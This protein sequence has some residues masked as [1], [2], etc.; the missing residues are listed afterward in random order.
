MIVHPY[1]KKP[2]I[3]RIAVV[4]DDGIYVDE[5]GATFTANSEYKFKQGQIVC[6][7]LWDTAI[8]LT[9]NGIG[10][11][12]SWNSKDTRWRAKIHVDETDWKP[13]PL[14]AG[15]IQ[16]PVSVTLSFDDVLKE[17]VEFRDW[18]NDEGARASCTFGAMS[19]SLLRAK[20]SSPIFTGMGG[21]NNCP[22]IEFTRGGRQF[23]PDGGMGKYEGQIINWDLP[24]AYASTLGNIC[25]NGYWTKCYLRHAIK[26][27][28]NGAPVYCHA[29]VDIPNV[30]VGPL[31]LTLSRPPNP[32]STAIS[33]K[34][35]Y[36][37]SE[38]LEG[39]WTLSELFEAENVGCK[40]D[41]IIC[42]AMMT[43]NQPFTEWWKAILRGKE[44]DGAIARSLAKRTG[45]SLVGTFSKDPRVKGKKL[46]IHYVNGN[47]KIRRLNFH[48]NSQVPGHDLAEAITSAVRAKLYQHIVAAD[49]HL[50]SAHTDGLWV[51]GKYEVP[52]GWRIKQQA[53]R[54]D[55]IDPQ[56]LRYYI[57][58]WNSRVVMS[59]VPSKLAAEEFEKRWKKLECNLSN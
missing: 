59:G 1:Q 10:E 9:K 35:G 46:A 50:L 23:I 44:L 12:S 43:Q 15:I 40:V 22:P 55:L 51:K 5:S 3:P 24:S 38:R 21:R 13:R 56:N 7:V 18:L 33:H 29:T 27:H 34:F 20:I 48:P 36:P 16:F 39:I 42:W 30:R 45:N 31:P 25:W 26:A 41:Y 11:F 58:T 14:D 4:N 6:Y 17:I 32:L 37:I 47:R 53:K 8:S 28:Q 54:I 52:N 19:I 57:D 49:E 2:K